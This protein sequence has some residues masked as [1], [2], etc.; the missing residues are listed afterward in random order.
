MTGSFASISASH[1]HSLRTL[2]ALYE[3][4]SFMQSIR[5]V[6]DLGC[7]DGADLEWWATATTRDE[8]PRPLNIRCVGVDQLPALPRAKKIVNMTYQRQDFEQAIYHKDRFDLLWSHDS[9]QYAINPLETLRQWRA[10]TAVNGVLVLIVPQTVNMEFKTE[11]FDQPDLCYYHWTMTS[12]IHAL[13]VSGW[14]CKS[15]YFLKQPNDHWLHAMVYNS[16]QPDRDPRATRWYDLV[17]AKLLPDSADKS[18]QRHGYLRQR[19]L[20]LPWLDKNL[21]W[22]G[23]RRK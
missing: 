22:L 20:I 17:D 14:D 19:D 16:G 18:I 23:Q 1:E 13:A 11:A 10:A 6:C 15:G 8:N 4:D 3:Y 5:S 12:L 9:F 7:G 21:A 2:N